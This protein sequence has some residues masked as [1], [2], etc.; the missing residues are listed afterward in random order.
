M[1]NPSFHDA[2]AQKGDPMKKLISILLTLTMLVTM[3]ACGKNSAAPSG[4]GSGAE[5]VST[6]AP[7]TDKSTESPS[8]ADSGETDLAV[9]YPV[10]VTDQLGREVTIQ[11]K[12]EKLVSGYYISTSLLI[13]L[14]LKD[15]LVGIEAKADSR[16]IYR[17]SA[18]QIISLPSVGTAKEFDLEGCAALEPDLV[19][20]PAKLESVIPSLEELGITVIAV[21]PEDKNLLEEAVTLLGTAT[22]T[23]ARAQELLSFHDK[24]LE[25]LS[26]ALLNTDAPSVYLAGNS[27][28]LSAAGPKM[29]QDNLIRQAGGAN[30]AAEITEDYWADISYEQLLAWDPDYIILAADAEYT[31]DSVLQDP[32]LQDCTAVK[33]RNVYQF[34]NAIEAWDS[35]VPSSILGSMWLAS[36]LHPQ[37]YDTENWKQAVTDY[38]ETFYG[39]TPDTENLYK[40]AE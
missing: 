5:N 36:V 31:T 18:P 26:E 32:N 23:K 8:S 35:P 6:E 1:E 27:T 34:P 33:N 29:Y 2:N 30:V 4:Q 22:D 13:A 38:Y 25:P 28:F 37:E 19:L 10:T 21:N 3:T 7:G 9:T 15:S 24:Q 11:Q 12:P 40:K 20:L 16:D 14:G 39:F 17:L